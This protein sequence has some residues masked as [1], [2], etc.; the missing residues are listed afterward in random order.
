[1]FNCVYCFSEIGLKFLIQTKIDS[2]MKEGEKV[3]GRFGQFSKKIIELVY[4]F[5]RVNH[6]KLVIFDGFYWLYSDV[7]KN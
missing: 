2:L 1:M 7:G 6:Q 5:M 3:E 4:C